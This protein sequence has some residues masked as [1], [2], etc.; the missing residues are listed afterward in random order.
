MAISARVERIIHEVEALNDV[1]RDELMCAL[2]LVEKPEF[3]R[4]WRDEINRRTEE[5]D[6]G[7]VNLVSED[8][9]FKNLRQR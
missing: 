2:E 1:E 9:F 8:D 6:Q 5:V 4:E 3:G 7:R